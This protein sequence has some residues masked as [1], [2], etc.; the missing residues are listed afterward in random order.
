MCVCDST[1]CSLAWMSTSQPLPPP[2][3]AGTHCGHCNVEKRRRRTA[4]R[5]RVAEAN[6]RERLGLRKS[7]TQR[8][9]DQK[10]GVSSGRGKSAQPRNGAHRLISRR[11][12]TKRITFKETTEE[13]ETSG[14]FCPSPSELHTSTT[15]GG[16]QEAQGRAGLLGG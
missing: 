8:R 11:R 15:V 9:E 12:K 13:E 14:I 1:V 10:T 4:A 16:T 6:G 5:R 3:A 2:R 7:G